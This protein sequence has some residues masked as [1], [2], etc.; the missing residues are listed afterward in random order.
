MLV[1]LL[2]AFPIVQCEV[3]V[4]RV[5]AEQ[6]VVNRCDF[7]RVLRRSSHELRLG[8]GLERE[9]AAAIEPAFAV[10]SPGRLGDAE[11]VEPDKDVMDTWATSSVSSARR[12]SAPPTW[13]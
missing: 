1:P 13:S 4:N 10:A 11:E 3:V 6:V 12:G 2:T 8:V 7:S 5:E 9:H